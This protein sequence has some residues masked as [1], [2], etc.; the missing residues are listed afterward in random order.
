MNGLAQRE[1]EMGMAPYP[2]VGDPMAVE[3][4]LPPEERQ[5]VIE[6]VMQLLQADPSLRE[7]L[8]AA[9]GAV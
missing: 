3:G 2:S 7:D 5:R 9:L 4:G 8:L 1:D 6:M